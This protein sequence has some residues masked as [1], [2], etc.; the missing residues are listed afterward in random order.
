MPSTWEPATSQRKLRKW[1]AGEQNCRRGGQR[2]SLM[3]LGDIVQTCIDL[4]GI[5]VAFGI[6]IA[7]RIVTG[8]VSRIARACDCKVAG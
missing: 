3:I 6:G 2:A 8:A 5:S 7:E 4:T 1:E